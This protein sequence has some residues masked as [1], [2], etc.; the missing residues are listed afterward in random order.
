[1]TDE[2]RLLDDPT[3]DAALRSALEA[4][5]A[6]VPSAERLAS[7]A[8]KLPPIPTG[9]GGGAGGGGGAG[10]PPPLPMN[11]LPVAAKLLIAGAGIAAAVG[12]GAV[13]MNS[14]STAAPPS[15]VTTVSSTI[16]VPSVTASAPMA[17][18][19]VAP[20]AATKPVI[21][22]TPSVSAPPPDP[23]LDTSL[24]EEASRVVATQPDVALAKCAEH[25]K[26]FPKSSL[27]EERDR[28]AIEALVHLHRDA[29]ART[30]AAT[31]AKR[32]PGSAYQRRIDAL[33]GD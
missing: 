1:M 32:Y 10:A 33:F 8:A 17:S 22:P 12:L 28:I 16:L 5:R 2:K 29:E 13:A 26:L 25:E 3:I 18:A 30:R 24:V 19:S 4:G 9:P 15:S 11:G 20:S 31:F 7:I 6:E 21:V 14:G 27:A 23:A